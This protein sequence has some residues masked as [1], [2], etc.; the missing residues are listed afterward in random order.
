MRWESCARARSSLA[1]NPVAA[2]GAGS[3]TPC[4]E[5][6]VRPRRRL[7]GAS[8]GRLSPGSRVAASPH[9]APLPSSRPCY[10]PR[11]CCCCFWPAAPSPRLLSMLP[12]RRSR[13][14]K[15]RRGGRRS[16]SLRGSIFSSPRRCG[17]RD[18]AGEE[19]MDRG[20]VAC[21]CV[22]WSR[23]SPFYGAAGLGC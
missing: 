3:R 9:P 21:V 12:S 1:A 22:E 23:D 17:G 11:S 5:E 7:E 20:R 10:R 19:R 16:G 14:T 18:G 13:S 2:V 15:K 8:P 4:K 6:R